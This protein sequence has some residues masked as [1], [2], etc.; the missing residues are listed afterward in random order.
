MKNRKTLTSI[1]F[2]AFLSIVLVSFVVK[3]VNTTQV[4]KVAQEVSRLRNYQ[5]EQF[6]K[7]QSSCWSFT[8]ES[9]AVAVGNPRS[10][11]RINSVSSAMSKLVQSSCIYNSYRDLIYVNP[12]KGLTTRDLNNPVPGTIANV[13]LQEILL[14][15]DSGIPF[16]KGGGSICSDGSTSPSTG[17]GSCSYHGGYA[18][19]RGT[20]W[21]MSA[22]KIEAPHP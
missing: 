9:D 14:D 8:S 17:Q 1:A 20:K 12:F 18:V 15:V 7:L 19:K 22:W 3:A 4:E 2:L 5:Q 16:L 21:D 10:S 11:A 13:L 6:I